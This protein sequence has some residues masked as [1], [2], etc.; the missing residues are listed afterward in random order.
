MGQPYGNVL[1]ALHSRRPEGVESNRRQQ[2]LVDGV[3][4]ISRWEEQAY[5]LGWSP[6]DL[7]GLHP[8][9]K[10]QTATLQRRLGRYDATGLIW[11]LQGKP[12]VAL[13]EAE[14]AIQSCGIV[15]LPR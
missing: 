2:A 8:Y 4:F 15:R 13:T 6:R 12:V 1:A 14:A 10:N 11:L 5:R 3:A 9:Q 7:F